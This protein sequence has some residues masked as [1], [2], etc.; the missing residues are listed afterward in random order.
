MERRMAGVIM[1]VQPIVIAVHVSAQLFTDVND[2]LIKTLQVK[3]ASELISVPCIDLNGGKQIEINFDALSASYNRY[4]YSV[5]H[6]DADW[7]PSVLTPVEYMSGFQGLVIDDYASGMGT[8][9]SYT[10][11]RLLLPNRDVQFKV[12]GNY[13]VRICE[14]DKPGHIVLTACFSVVEPLVNISA[15]VTGNTL[16]DTYASR[17]QVDFTVNHKALSIPY[18]Q[19]ELKVR[20]CQNNRRDNVVTDILPSGISAGRIEYANLRELIFEAGNE[21]RRFEFL[22]PR[23]NGMHVDGVSFHHPYYHVT[24]ASDIPRSAHSYQYD[25][26]QNGRF[27]INCINCNNPDVQADYFFVHFTLDADPLAGGSVHIAG[28][29]YNNVLDEKSKMGY[30]R[31][32]GRYEKSLLLKQ[33]NYN[34]H[35]LFLPNGQSRA[36]AALTEGDYYQSENEYGIYIYYRPQGERYDRLI[37]AERICR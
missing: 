24:L 12:S 36:S 1:L 13:A 20:V 31:E 33:G 18:P 19:S 27:F 29:I 5:I 35:Y 21:Y 30:N 15:T 22:S 4:A 32:T 16:I 28:D 14:E 37:G 9:V 17:Q 26:D 6:C 11:Y 8:T 3:T 34:Y 7:K 25:Q 23:Y 10:N 2:R